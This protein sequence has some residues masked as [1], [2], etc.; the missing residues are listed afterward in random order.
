MWSISRKAEAQGDALDDFGD[1]RV[2]ADAGVLHR[3]LV[4]LDVDVVAVLEE[5]DHHGKGRVDEFQL[6]GRRR[7]SRSFNS[8][9]VRF[10]KSV[11][12]RASWP[13]ACS[14]GFGAGCCAAPRPADAAA[15]FTPRAMPAGPLRR[16]VEGIDAAAQQAQRGDD[17]HGGG[18]RAGHVVRHQRAAG[19]GGFIAAGQADGPHQVGQRHFHRLGAAIGAEQ[20]PQGGQPPRAAHGRRSGRRRGVDQ[21]QVAGPRGRAGRQPDQQA[22]ALALRLQRHGAVGRAVGPKELRRPEFGVLGQL[23]FQVEGLGA[24]REPRLGLAGAVGRQQRQQMGPL[25]DRR[26]ERIAAAA[27]DVDRHRFLRADEGEDAPQMA[28]PADTRPPSSARRRRRGGRR[29][30]LARPTRRCPRPRPGPTGRPRRRPA[31][32][33]AGSRSTLPSF[34]GSGCLNSTARR[35]SPPVASSSSTFHRRTVSPGL[36]GSQSESFSRVPPRPKIFRVS[37]VSR[38]SSS[39]TRRARASS[40]W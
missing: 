19:P 23:D 37:G 36:A 31:P 29:H 40:T 5:V 39:A 6:R 33:A 30:G 25:G 3:L 9:G 21:L 38:G 13:A 12:K 28:A 27:V 1:R 2:R 8:P 4:Q 17:A 18:Q 14:C 35:T 22:V 24:E 34:Q 20:E 16:R 7:A 32:P 26:V 10:C 15:L 11:A